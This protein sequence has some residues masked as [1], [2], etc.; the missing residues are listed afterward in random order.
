MITLQKDFPAL[1][2]K[3]RPDVVIA[4]YDPRFITNFIGYKV[5][6]RLGIKWIWWGHGIRPRDK[7]HFIY[8]KMADMADAIILYGSPAKEKLALLGVRKD[9]LFVAWNSIDTSEIDKYYSPTPYQQR[10]RILYIG[11]LVPGKKIGVLIDAFARALSSMSKDTILTLIGD[12]PERLRL[13]SICSSHNIF[14]NV[15]FTGAL[16][17][18]DTISPYMNT[19]F[20]S[21]SPGPIGLSAIQCLAYAVPLLVAD[22]EPHGPEES[23]IEEH[24]NGVYFKSNSVEDLESHLLDLCINREK[25]AEMGAAGRIAAYER[26]SVE[27]MVRSF[28]KALDYVLK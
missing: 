5:A 19:S 14:Q 18:Q 21:I 9:M 23:V 12:G 8:K 13:H 7:Y 25:V 26:F 3:L 4:G 10:Y 11:R 16:Y 15:E 17:T 20:L 27:A 1:I 22:N 28:Q 2:R 6:R 24:V